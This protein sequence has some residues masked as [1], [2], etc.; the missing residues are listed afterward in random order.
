MKEKKVVRPMVKA[1]ASLSSFTGKKIHS[2]AAFELG[3]AN[4]PKAF[5]AGIRYG[6]M[7]PDGD[8]CGRAVPEL[9]Q[10]TAAIAGIPAAPMV[11]CDDWGNELIMTSSATIASAEGIGKMISMVTKAP[12][13]KATCAHAGFL[14]SGK[15]MKELICPGTFTLSYQVGKAI[16]EARETGT[17]PAM[18]AAQAGGGKII[19]S[20]EVRDVDWVS[21]MGYMTGTATIQGLENYSGKE[22]TVW[23]QNENHIAKI[24]SAAVVMSPDMIHIV[25]TVMGEP[26]TN[27][28]LAKNAKVTVI[29]T[30]NPR[31]RTAEGLV[32]LGPDHFGFD[33]PY[34]PF[35]L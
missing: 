32:A 11:I 22:M 5:D 20:G 3:G 30:P 26:I 28:R 9:S 6:A 15:M 1:I 17:Q 13:P 24:D 16:R 25:D 23:F 8:F 21:E 12:D 18:A 2:V 19:F 7:V 27:T 31:Y 4:S 14:V 10:T 29:A 33:I 35:D 34:F